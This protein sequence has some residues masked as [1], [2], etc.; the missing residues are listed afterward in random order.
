LKQELL[1]PAVASVQLSAVDAE[2][3]G[4]LVAVEKPVAVAAAVDK[5]AMASAT[6]SAA[7][8]VA[9]AEDMP[10]GMLE[11]ALEEEAPP[12]KFDSTRAD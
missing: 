3:A 9:V 12:H 2:V 6:M 4:W 1:V 10:A 11:A 7:A 5:A 8:A